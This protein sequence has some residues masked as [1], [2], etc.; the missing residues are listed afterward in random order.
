MT[1][2]GYSLNQPEIPEIER[3]ALTIEEIEGALLKSYAVDFSPLRLS[4]GKP[5]TIT[6]SGFLFFG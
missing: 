1:E 3:E 5:R 2:N 4:I 6:P